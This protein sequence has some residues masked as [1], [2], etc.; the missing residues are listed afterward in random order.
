MGNPSRKNWEK[1]T[2]AVF[3]ILGEEVLGPDLWVD[4]AFREVGAQLVPNPYVLDLGCGNGRLVPVLNK[5]GISR[6]VGI[7]VSEGMIRVARQ[8]YPGKDFRVGNIL[9]L[10]EVV[11]Q[12]LFDG[13]FAI[14]SLMHILRENMPRAA[15]SIRSVLK[16]GAIGMITTPCGRGET[17]MTADR[18]DTNGGVIPRGHYMYR[19]LWQIDDLASYFEK[20]GFAVC[21]P[22]FQDKTKIDLT[23]QAV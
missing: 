3:D 21:Q 14:V 5:L 9:A 19:A 16:T 7:D 23:V 15:T 6:F 4:P 13:F 11:G 18:A 8:I 12:D 1:L 20:A 22:S 10:Q 17:L 2:I